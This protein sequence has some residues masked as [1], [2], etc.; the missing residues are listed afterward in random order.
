M[1]QMIV[2]SVYPQEAKEMLAFPLLVYI[3]PNALFPLM[4]LFLLLKPEEY[5]SYIVLYMAGKVL[6]AAA[7]V[8][9]VIFSFSDIW[10]ALGSF[11]D[12]RAV[13]I[14]NISPLLIGL[15]VL[16]VFGGHLLNKGHPTKRAE[17]IG[18]EV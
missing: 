6:A 13:R 12:G 14:L 4:A 1:I 11:L 5:R 15:D 10:P 18:E 3:A 8:G 7:G 16:S 9:W 17:R 2:L